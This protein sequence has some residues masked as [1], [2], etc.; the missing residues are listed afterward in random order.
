M[1]GQG[2]IIVDAYSVLARPV[3]DSSEMFAGPTKDILGRPRIQHRTYF[4]Q[5]AYCQNILNR[6]LLMLDIH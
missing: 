1:V 6:V 3:G 4:S 5:Y 2:V